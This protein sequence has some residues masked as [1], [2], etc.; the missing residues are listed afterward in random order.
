MNFSRNR[1]YFNW[2]WL[3]PRDF[4]VDH[5]IEN[6]VGVLK[7]VIHPPVEQNTQLNSDS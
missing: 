3:K 6:L 5:Q 7:P 4:L 1:E 2:K